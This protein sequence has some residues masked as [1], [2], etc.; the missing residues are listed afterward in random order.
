MER[1]L[2]ASF[3]VI[4]LT[5][6]VSSQAVVRW[7]VTKEAEEKKCNDMLQAIMTIQV[8]PV[9]AQNVIPE[10]R[11]AAGLNK[12]MIPQLN[13]IRGVD[14]TDCMQM[15]ENDKADL[16]TL[17]AGQGYFAGRYHSMMPIMAEIYNQLN[18]SDVEHYAVAVRKKIK[19]MI[20][21]NNL[22]GARVC[23][24]GIG[25]GAGWVY[26]VAFL[27]QNQLITVYECNAVVKT[28]T[29]FF[30]P[31]CL[32]GAL[33]SFYN[34]F[35][36]NPTRVCDLCIG[37]GVEQCTSSDPN[38]GEDGAFRC[39]SSD[40]GDIAFLR[41]NT[42]QLQAL[43][44]GVD[45]GDF[46]L[47]CPTGG[48]AA[49]TDYQQCN[50]GKVP[51]NIVM[52][53]SMKN[54][55]TIASYKSFLKQLVEW[56]A[57]G[58]PYTNTFSIFSSTSYSYLKRSN[59]LFSDATKMLIDVRDR[60][61]YY[62]WTGNEFRMK[63][64]V[65]N[66]CPLAVA[67]F[68][69]ISDAEQAKCE[70]MVEAFKGNDLKPDLDCLR[71]TNIRHCMSLIQE[72]DADMMVLDAGD[73]YVAGK[74][75]GLVPIA[76]EDYG[77]MT[78]S[79]K[80]VAAALKANLN[81]TLFNLKNRRACHAGIGRGDGWIIPL[82]VYIETQQFLPQQCS[83]FENIGQ[84]FSRS[85]IPG[86]L[87]KEYNRNGKPINLCEGCAAGG[88]RKCQRNSDE[89]Y[90]GPKGAF[91]CLVEKAGDVAFVRHLTVRDN[92]DGRNQAIWARNRR[93]DDYEI[94]CK[95]GRRTAI[96]NWERCFVGTVPSNA[97]VTAGF[98]TQAER[99]IYWNLF[100]NA[101]QFFSSDIDGD[102]HLFDSGLFYSDL[103]FNDDAVRLMKI[104][105]DMQDYKKYLG[106]DFINQIIYLEDYTCTT[107]SSA[108]VA[109]L[110]FV[111]SSL[112]LIVN[113]M[114]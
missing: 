56:F 82:N 74:Y 89:P 112:F 92:T 111:L 55:A 19:P 105:E 51:N 5:E 114:V 63:L 113:Y 94:M 59:L 91:R 41:H 88:Y 7:C 108:T 15:I 97:I 43:V 17:E 65:L 1:L 64:D 86:A 110:S 34:P 96:D 80:V 78:G 76:A 58:K 13:C 48:S 99:D 4:V 70:M 30:G 38:A 9:S 14:V 72:G 66:Y 37:S 27:L 77:D 57:A 21:I 95:D 46:E 62:S 28:V 50:F 24:P 39:L 69:V 16:I 29:E 73:L 83:I 2:Y 18:L 103:I 8:N 26:P 60:D 32:P 100:S 45:P 71:G 31:M 36:N 109:S 93:S 68:C 6:M 90:Y 85:C 84:L 75:Y 106:Y 42:V 107:T 49:I 40:S 10:F 33:T 61:T 44:E 79:F 35:G 67:R 20:N 22:Q 11:A 102:F 52:T 25:T 23:D 3:I 53:S 98:K 81:M 12:N 54:A 104:E 87:E 101:Q 47:I